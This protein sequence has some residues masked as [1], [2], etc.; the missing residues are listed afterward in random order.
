MIQQS[1]GVQWSAT[2]CRVKVFELDV[3]DFSSKSCSVVWAELSKSKT[4]R[5][6]GKVQSKAQLAR[7][8]MLRAAS[9]ARFRHLAPTWKRTQLSRHCTA[10]YTSREGMASNETKKANRLAKE[11]SPYLLQHQFNPV[12]WYVSILTSENVSRR[13]G[14]REHGR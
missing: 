14:R 3:I 4:I 1:S 8:H 9:S 5:K 12:D 7:V 2:S 10:R 11:K 6:E 13:H